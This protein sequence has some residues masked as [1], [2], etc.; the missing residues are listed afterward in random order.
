[1]AI[2][3]YQ[4]LMLPVLKEA[5][6]GEVRIGGVV[7]SLANKLALTPEDRSALLPSGKQSIFTN[8]VHWAKSYLS[9]AGLVELTKRGHFKIPLLG[10]EILASDPAAIDNRFLNQFEEFRE[11]R[12]RTAEAD[13]KASEPQLSSGLSD[14]K[15]TPDEIMHEAHRQIETALAQDLLSRV[16]IAPPDFFERLIV[17][18]LISMGYD[19][20]NWRTRCRRWRR[21]YALAPAVSRETHQSTSPKIFHLVALL[22]SS[23][24]YLWFAETNRSE[25]CTRWKR[26]TFKP[27]SR[28]DTRASFLLS[29]PRSRTAVSTKMTL[30]GAMMGSMESPVKCMAIICSGCAHHASGA[31][32]TSSTFT[33]DRLTFS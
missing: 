17:N 25:P 27:R 14:Q 20:P 31:S 1:M 7:E 16:R 33:W 12:R 10:K 26:A 11:F 2:A 8:R 9:K 15:E 5:A 21:R 28:C 29:T 19:R 18:L 24:A 4:S 22:T 30:P 32:S 3:D 23:G 6:E 13:E